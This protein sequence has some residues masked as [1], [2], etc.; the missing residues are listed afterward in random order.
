MPALLEKLAV[1]APKPSCAT[2]ICMRTT[3][4]KASERDAVNPRRTTPWRKIFQGHEE[5]LGYTPD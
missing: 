3:V 1:E 5:Y 2:D 4:L